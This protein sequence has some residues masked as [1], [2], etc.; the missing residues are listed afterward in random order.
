[1]D[2]NTCNTKNLHRIIGRRQ[3]VHQMLQGRQRRRTRG[4]S[5]EYVTTGERSLTVGRGAAGAQQTLWNTD[6][7]NDHQHSTHASHL[8][9]IQ[10][11]GLQRHLIHHRLPSR[12][13]MFAFLCSYHLSMAHNAIRGCFCTWLMHC[14]HENQHY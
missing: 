7:S 9:N 3:N 12:C 5:T 4:G 13:K 14:Y 11:H 10:V 6:K 2:S 1:M 8:C